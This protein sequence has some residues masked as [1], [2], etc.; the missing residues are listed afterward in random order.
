MLEFHGKYI[1]TTPEAK[2][3]VRYVRID[4]Y[5][6][7]RSPYK[8]VVNNRNVYWDSTAKSVSENKPSRGCF[9]S[10]SGGI[11]AIPLE[12]FAKKGNA[13]LSHFA[14]NVMGY[15]DSYILFLLEYA[16]DDIVDMD[17]N[18]IVLRQCNIVFICKPSEFRKYLSDYTIT[19]I[20]AEFAARKKLMM[21]NT[22]A[23]RV[24]D[25]RKETMPFITFSKLSDASM[26]KQYLMAQQ[27]MQ[28]G[29]T[30]ITFAGNV[31]E[32]RVMT[33][34]SLLESV[35]PNPYG[36]TEIHQYVL[37]IRNRFLS[38]LTDGQIGI[39][40]QALRSSR[41]LPFSYDA[42]FYHDV[43]LFSYR[44]AFGEKVETNEMYSLVWRGFVSCGYRG[45]VFFNKKKIIRKSLLRNN[46]YETGRLAQYQP[47]NLENLNK[48]EYS[49]HDR[50]S[51]RTDHT[52]ME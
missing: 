26:R 22:Y 35:M 31:G 49:L 39:L 32:E 10:C 47:P 40:E 52:V 8:S 48:I 18:E 23:N 44:S 3:A 1:K 7:L 43:R 51:A 2:F 24:V 41:E 15:D 21:E 29:I 37:S 33:W 42:G 20:K 5:G 9:I 12:E 17:D 36:E 13:R 4:E 6:K 16:Q 28:H 46:P 45:Q 11:Y 27:T 25:Y 50:E 30:A 38:E 34:F 19:T 14:Q